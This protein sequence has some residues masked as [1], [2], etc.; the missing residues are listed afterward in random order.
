[1]NL[2]LARVGCQGDDR[3]IRVPANAAGS[4]HAV[5]AGHLYVHEDHIELG[6]FGC[7]ENCRAVSGGTHLVP[8]ALEELLEVHPIDGVVLGDEDPQRTGGSGRNHGAVGLVGPVG[9][10]DLVGLADLGGHIE[11]EGTALTC[12]ALH[13]D[14]AAHELHELS[15]DREPEACSFELFAERAVHLIETLEHPR[16]RLLRNPDSTV[17]NGE[18]KDR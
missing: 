15:G 4:F 11:P 6:L 17:G 13:V 1:M 2:L 18:A 12:G 7:L 9:I 8:L 3:D 10:P 5:D 14:F 16:Q